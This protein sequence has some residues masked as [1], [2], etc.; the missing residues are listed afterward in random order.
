MAV[1]CSTL[2]RKWIKVNWT[3]TLVNS[4]R[5]F[6]GADST[7]VRFKKHTCIQDT[8]IVM[9]LRETN[10]LVLYLG[11]GHIRIFY[12]RQLVEANVLCAESQSVFDEV[13]R[14]LQAG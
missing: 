8:E 5:A 10:K 1:D 11:L 3:V 14:C 9:L 6:E 7:F 4:F 13:S 2:I 12:W